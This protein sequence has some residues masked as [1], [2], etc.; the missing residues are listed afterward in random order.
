MSFFLTTLDLFRPLS[1]TPSA[2]AISAHDA[3][4]RLDAK[5]ARGPPPRIKWVEPQQSVP[6]VATAAHKHVCSGPLAGIQLSREIVR[7]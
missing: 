6:G 1:L 3:N 4:D 5:V 2:S 7:G